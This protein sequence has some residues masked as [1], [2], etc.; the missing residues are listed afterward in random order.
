M[1]KEKEKRK[2]PK[3]NRRSLA[4]STSRH[5]SPKHEP[6]GAEAHGK[7]GWSKD[8]TD[9]IPKTSRGTSTHQERP[10][11]SQVSGKAKGPNPSLRKGPND[12]LLLTDYVTWNGPDH[13]NRKGPNKS[14][15]KG[16]N[17]SNRCG[18]SGLA[19][20]PNPALR[21]GPAGK[22][23][24]PNGNLSNGALKEYVN[25]VPRPQG[26]PVMVS[27]MEINNVWPLKLFCNSKDFSFISLYKKRKKFERFA[28]LLIRS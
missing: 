24:G 9:G 6:K 7:K 21:K 28:S 23:N 19:N 22:S 16:P 27:V 4:E 14:I 20:G 11:K 3:P 15:A 18:P 13:D 12:D 8:S 1:G 10:Y 17:A 26:L 2:S 5:A 25:S